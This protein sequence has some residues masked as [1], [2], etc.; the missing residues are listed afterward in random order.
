M[1]EFLRW[2]IE[3]PKNRQTYKIIAGI[4]LVMVNGNLSSIT[5]R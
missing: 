4:Q 2:G 1:N 3:N 5:Q